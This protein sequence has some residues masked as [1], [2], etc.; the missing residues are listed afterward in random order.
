MSA[1][2]VLLIALLFGAPGLKLL[3]LWRRTR[4]APEGF[5]AG[6]FLSLSVAAPLRFYQAGHP[7]LGTGVSLAASLISLCG[8]PASVCFLNL[9]T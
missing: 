6:F 9:F 5:L 1:V 2:P 7:E 3:A 4:S 8:L